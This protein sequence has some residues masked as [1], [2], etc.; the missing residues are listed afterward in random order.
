MLYQLSYLG[1]SLGQGPGAPVYSQAGD[2]C[3]PCFAFGYA[4]RGLAPPRRIPSPTTAPRSLAPLRLPNCCEITAIQHQR[5]QGLAAFDN[6]GLNRLSPNPVPRSVLDPD[7][8]FLDDRSPFVGLRFQEG[9]ELGLCRAL[10]IRAEFLESR[11]HR[12]MNQRR[13][14][15]GV[16]AGNDV[17]RRLDR[18]E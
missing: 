12:R 13:I 10:R 4:W 2:P 14:G 6:R 11:L 3:P 15:V 9:G 16:D 5:R 7:L 17:P 1:T 18:H 8:R